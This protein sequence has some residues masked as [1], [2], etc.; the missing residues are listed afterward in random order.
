MRILDFGKNTYQYE[1]SFKF[2]CFS[3]ERIG[4]LVK[5]LLVTKKSFSTVGKEQGTG[6][7]VLT[8]GDGTESAPFFQLKVGADKVVLWAGWYA[9]YE[10][11]RRWRD[12]LLS[13][14]TALLEGIPIEMVRLL[15]SQQ[16]FVIPIE[17]SKPYD[18]ISELEPVWALFG[19]FIPRELLKR[20][21]AS[22]VF[23]DE[24][25]NETLGWWPVGTGV[26][27]ETSIAFALNWNV[28][29]SKAGLKENEL[30]HV[31]RFDRLLE[32][33]HENYLSLLVKT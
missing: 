31:A 8:L 1:I 14:T 23:G 25:G 16:V 21:G 22:L 12:S 11:W 17:K 10:Q 29:N 5:D 19:R 3:P 33:F 32:A 7:T 13:E 24:E 9:T 18:Q 27:G 6:L 2:D 26:A 15:S 30:A 28:L 20:M 4:N